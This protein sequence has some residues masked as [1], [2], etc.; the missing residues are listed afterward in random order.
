MSEIAY[1][2]K[3][4]PRLSEPYITGEIHRVEQAGMKMRLF[5]IK[6][7]EE[8]ERQSSY[9]VVDRI[10]AQCVYL[11]GLSGLGGASWHGWIRDNLPKMAPS[12]RTVARR[13]PLG[14]ARA[15][16]AAAAQTVRAR[17]D[18][19]LP[20]L[21]LKELC[22][23]IALSAE[24]ADCPNVTRMHAHY[25]HGATTVAWLASMI[26]GLPFTFTAHARDI[27]AE[28]LNPAG[29]LKRKMLAA[30]FVVTCTGA[31]RDHLLT[32]APEATVHLVYHGLA[33][34]VEDKLTDAPP[35]TAP[36]GHLRLLGVGR[37]VRKKGFD[38]FVEACG[39]LQRRGV[40]FEAAIVGP[41]GEH[42]DEVRARIRELGLED[43]IALPGSMD[44]AALCDAYR[45]ADALC[46]PCRVLAEDRDG[47]PNVLVEA[48]AC[49]I[50]VVT[51]P[52]SGIPELVTD[53][54]NGLLV[55]EDDPIAVA[56]ALQRLREEPELGERIGAEGERT[57]RER[58]DGGE[59]AQRLVSLF[60][61]AVA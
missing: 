24:L 7:V 38:V 57:V 36:N 26:T 61:G 45:G 5:A 48:M 58:F 54:V 1:V 52:I 50:P 44:Q 4:Y 28:S 29:L 51:T 3:A 10:R 8:W 12:L 59:L 49:G 47:I 41:D 31:N 2:L 55:P 18:G 43:K 56:D 14:L 15:F 11:P 9:P 39:E 34:D 22:Q 35:R 42:G 25:A 13:H 32:V 27:Y 53:G 40:P 16:A 17:Q 19:K 20:K 30:E 21:Y 37:L 60:D 6:P 23:A 33:V 46:Q